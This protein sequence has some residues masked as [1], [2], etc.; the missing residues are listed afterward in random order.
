MDHLVEAVQMHAIKNYADPGWDVVTECWTGEEI[1]AW[2]EVESPDGKLVT[3]TTE[4]EAINKMAILVDVW[5]DQQ[6][7]DNQ[8]WRF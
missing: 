1:R 7:T 2:L 8:L 3:A 5:A 4:E 6:G